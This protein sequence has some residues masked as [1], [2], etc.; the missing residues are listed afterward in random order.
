MDPKEL[1]VVDALSYD[2]KSV[3][4]GMERIKAKLEDTPEINLIRDLLDAIRGFDA[5]Y[6]EACDNFDLDFGETPGTSYNEGM[7]VEFYIES[8]DWHQVSLALR[9]LD[10]KLEKDDE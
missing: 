7:T 5:I 4:R 1:D 9:Q 2:M 8:D 6:K 10:S 3:I